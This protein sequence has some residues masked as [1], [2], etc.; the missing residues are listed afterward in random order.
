MGHPTPFVIA[1][2]VLG[3]A[4]GLSLAAGT[5]LWAG[6]DDAGD[7]AATGGWHRACPRHGRSPAGSSFRQSDREDDESATKG[8]HEGPPMRPPMLR[9]TPSELAGA[10]QVRLVLEEKIGDEK[11]GD[12]RA[13]SESPL[14]ARRLQDFFAG[15]K[16][17]MALVEEFRPVEPDEDGDKKSPR[18]QLEVSLTVRFDRT[19]KMYGE[20]PIYYIFKGQA[21][22]KLTEMRGKKKPKKV[23]SIPAIDE[24]FSISVERKKAEGLGFARQETLRHVLHHLSKLPF[25]RA[26]GAVEVPLEEPEDE[27]EDGEE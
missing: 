17:P 11:I 9:P 26:R 3:L 6:G 10:P 4:M 1:V 12:P 19:H 7:G 16:Q 20:M 25:L 5:P 15:L 13:S 14:A 18:Y 2:A 22:C 24:E 21:V 23:A 27:T 8:R